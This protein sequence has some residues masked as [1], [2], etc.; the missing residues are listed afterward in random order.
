MWATRLLSWLNRCNGK[1]CYVCRRVA[2]YISGFRNP[3]VA[4]CQLTPLLCSLTFLRLYLLRMCWDT[5]AICVVYSNLKDS[6]LAKKMELNRKHF[7]AI[8]FHNFQRRITQ[9]Q[10]IDD[11]N[12]IFA[13]EAPSRNSVYRWYDEFNWGCSSLQNEFR[14]DRPKSVVV[15]E[16]IIAV[17]QLILQDRH[18]T[19][20]KIETTLGI[21]GTSIHIASILHEHLTVKKSCSRWIPHKFLIVKKNQSIRATKVL[22]QLVQTHAKVY[23][24][25]WGGVNILKNNKTIFDV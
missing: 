23:K 21:S 22:R 20:R 18:V 14:E 17:R 25:Q 24:S 13:N 10:C 19:Y 16:T 9:Q 15:P 11:I 1:L 7:R 6:S 5:S 4:I 8:I 12:S 3:S 2:F